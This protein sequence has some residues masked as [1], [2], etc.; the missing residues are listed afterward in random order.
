MSR[1]L[2]LIAISLLGVSI[3]FS[4]AS[5]EQDKMVPIGPNV[6]ASLVI[7]FKSGV[8]D[9]QINNFYEEVLSKPKT[10]RGAAL[11]DGICMRLRVFPPVQN[12]EGI[13]ITFCKDATEDNREKLESAIMASPIVYKVLENVAPGDVKQLD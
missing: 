9:E 13:A 4:C 7:Y 11:Q 2:I 8:N 12:H 5:P 1:T 6:T 10:A 3:S